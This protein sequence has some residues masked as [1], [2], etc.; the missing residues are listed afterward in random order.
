VRLSEGLLRLSEELVN[1]WSLE[2]AFWDVPQWLMG[3]QGLRTV[4]PASSLHREEVSLGHCIMIFALLYA[5]IF[6]LL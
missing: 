3:I 2:K 4:S 5:T 6:A 1:I